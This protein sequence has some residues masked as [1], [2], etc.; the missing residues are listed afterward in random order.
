VGITTGKQGFIM[1]AGMITYFVIGI[2]AF[3]FIYILFGGLIDGFTSQVN[4]QTYNDNVHTSQLRMDTMGILQKFWFVVPVI[5]LFV[6]G[7]LLIK[8]SLR[9][10][11]GEIY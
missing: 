10:S 3:A 7:F 9:E 11:S 8:N 6:M 1:S 5:F 4:S 2:L